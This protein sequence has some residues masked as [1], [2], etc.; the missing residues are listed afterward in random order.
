MKK[1][2]PIFALLILSTVIHAVALLWPAPRNTAIT[3][4]LPDRTYIKLSL[5][6]LPNGKTETDQEIRPVEPPLRKLPVPADTQKASRSVKTVK[7]AQTPKTAAPKTTAKK[8]LTKPTQTA[9]T[10]PALT[11]VPADSESSQTQLTDFDPQR[12]KIRIQQLINLRV[13]HNQHYPRL[14][15]KRAWEGQVKLGM[16]V[17]SDGQLTGIHVI[18]SSGH[19]ILDRAAM[20]SI[21]VVTHLPEAR[22]WLQGRSIDVILPVIYQLT[23]S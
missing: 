20:K 19:R 13:R 14:A 15:R 4:A 16:Q 23:D 17:R 1:N 12:L 2:I 8:Q 5:N 22:E 6:H 3:R 21:S 10:V 9:R 11:E 7:R 18:A